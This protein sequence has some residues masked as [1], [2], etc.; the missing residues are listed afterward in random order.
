MTITSS[1]DPRLL[2]LAHIV[3]A[4]ASSPTVE[5]TLVSSSQ[6]ARAMGVHP[7]TLIQ[8]TRKRHKSLQKPINFWKHPSENVGCFISVVVSDG[9]HIHTPWHPLHS[10]ISQKDSSI[11]TVHHVSHRV[12]RIL[13]APMLAWFSSLL[14][15][16][17]MRLGWGIWLESISNHNNIKVMMIKKVLGRIF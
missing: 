15:G 16:S 6:T 1:S 14:S 17:F 10:Y 2:T 5:P 11:V 9:I 13:F 8:L 4:R 3:R 7:E 12:A